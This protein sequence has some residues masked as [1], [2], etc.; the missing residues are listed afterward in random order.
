MSILLFNSFE[1]AIKYASL[2]PHLAVRKEL[3][4]PIDS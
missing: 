3:D 4:F 2:V 1:I